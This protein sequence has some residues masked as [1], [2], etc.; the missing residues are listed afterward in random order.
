MAAGSGT[1]MTGE[2][3][4]R[5][6]MSQAGEV[7]RLR[8]PLVKG[9]DFDRVDDRLGRLFEAEVAPQRH[10]G[11]QYPK[12]DMMFGWRVLWVGAQLLQ[13]VGFPS[14][15][16]GVILSVNRRKGG[17]SALELD[18]FVPTVALCLLEQ[19]QRA[20]GIAARLVQMLC[21]AGTSAAEFETF[22]GKVQTSFVTP[23]RRS[24]KVG[25]STIPVLRNVWEQGIPFR[26]M[27]NGAYSIGWGSKSM[28]INRSAVASDSAI[29]ANL[30]QDKML[31]AY[32]LRQAGLPTSTH[33]RVVS[34]AEA[35]QVAE[36]LGWPVVVK[37]VNRDRG[38]GVSVD[39]FDSEGL[40]VAFEEA[41]RYSQV[42]LVEKQ[43]AGVCHR[44]FVAYRKQVLFVSRR[45]P[46]SVK[47]DGSRTVRELIDEANREELE[48]VPW[49]RL[50]P[51]PV[52]GEAIKYLAAANLTLDSVPAKGQYAPLRRI[53]S[54]AEGGVVEDHT[55]NIHPENVA[56]A[57][58]AA[59]LFDLD[60]AGVDIIT[61]DISKP[62]YESG[63]IINEVN[64]ASLLGGRDRV[65]GTN[66]TGDFVSMLPVGNGRIPVIVYVGGEAAMVQAKI[67]QQELKI[68]GVR[69][70]VTSA[71]ESC[72][73]DGEPLR[74]AVVGLAARLVALL[75]QRD[76]DALCVVV[77]SDEIMRGGFPVDR[78]D[79]LI[80]VD[81]DLVQSD[82]QGKKLS[83]E[84]AEKLVNFLRL[85]LAK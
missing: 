67:R 47:G 18:A 42:V 21:D 84:Q 15:D 14:F 59:D 52:D 17:D 16:V 74:L 19:R 31:T 69:C 24:W 3:F 39:V 49:Q 27:G 38:E 50:K 4:F 7:I 80:R 48:K 79:E 25:N 61:E 33:A 20:Y 62:W 45:L 43:V 81:G 11:S 75:S 40:A 68:D 22:L 34:L 76:V 56:I 29:G 2:G 73:P 82:A 13:A 46:K 36:R 70:A 51:F 58:R 8:L 72:G 53:Q 57:I 23:A 64:Y 41:R 44:V 35:E 26:H 9:V 1:R 55:A 6:G 37:P 30:G 77:Q 66:Y 10:A 83:V 12:Q 85:Y 78:F 60:S 5:P 65:Q 32:R 63:A 71:G 28:L 54:N